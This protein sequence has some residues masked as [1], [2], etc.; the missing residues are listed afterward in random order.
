MTRLRPAALLLLAVL[1]GAAWAAC[2]PTG[3]ILCCTPHEELECDEIEWPRA[4]GVEGFQTDDGIVHFHLTGLPEGLTWTG[5]IVKTWEPVDDETE[6]TTDPIR[7]PTSGSIQSIITWNIYQNG[8]VIASGTDIDA[9][10]AE[11]VSGLVRCVFSVA[12]FADACGYDSQSYEL[13]QNFTQAQAPII[14]LDVSGG[15]VPRYSTDPSGRP[16]LTCTVQALE[17]ATFPLT[18]HLSGSRIRFEP[19]T[20]M[21]RNT[22]L[23]DTSPMSFDISGQEWS[24]VMNDGKIYARASSELGEVEAVAD[25]TVVW[26]EPIILRNNPKETIS[27]DNASTNKPSPTTLGTGVISTPT[28]NSRTMGNI[29]EIRGQVHPSNLGLPV[30]FSRDIVDELSVDCPVSGHSV[31]NNTLT[32]N[33]R[34]PVGCGTDNVPA[35]YCSSIP[36]N[37]GYVYDIDTPGLPLGWILSQHLLQGAILYRRYNFIEY[38]YMNLS[39][40]NVRVSDDFPWYSKTTVR[41]IPNPQDPGS[42]SAVFHPSKNDPSSNIAAPGQI[43]TTDL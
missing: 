32:K 30:R 37:A 7:T 20:Q 19:A 1:P 4:D 11:P 38:A 36:S 28:F 10:T 27:P 31:T 25:V 41:V 13:E 12:S 22:T 33:P 43:D 17:G 24:D 18:V 15:V 9:K 40:T 5:T 21:T 8:T 3:S 14:V 42:P 39:G 34:G 26:V 35:S 2:N 23:N 29:V 16:T 6:C